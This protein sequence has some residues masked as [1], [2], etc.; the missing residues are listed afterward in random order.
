MTESKNKPTSRRLPEWLKRPMPSGEKFGHVMNILKEK[1]LATVC[2]SAHCPNQGECYS[3]GT[4]TFMIMGDVCTRNCQFCAVTHG[5]VAPLSPDE[6][7]R[8]AE[9]VQSLGLKHIVITSVTRDDLPDGGAD[10]F[11]ATIQAVRN[12]TP[13]VTIEVLTPDFK[14]QTD[15]LDI[16]C[17]ARPDVFNHNVETSRRLTPEIR[18]GANYELSLGVL[19]YMADHQD[20]PIVKSGFMLGLGETDEEITEMLRDLH[21]AGVKMITI[22]QYLRPGPTNRSVHEYYRPEKFEA[23]KKRAEGIGFSHVAAG[24]FVR[25]SYHAELSLRD[26]AGPNT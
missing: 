13:N 9:A 22:G 5:E 11:A 18:S 21:D 25:S 24:P 14:G 20:G 3:C 26:S 12:L 6:P 23:I 10:H 16:V 7:T 19:K 17:A 8:L 1:N 4:A 15:C 2:S